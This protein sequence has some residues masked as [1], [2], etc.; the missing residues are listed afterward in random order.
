MDGYDN[1]IDLKWRIET[2]CE[3]LLI[4]FERRGFCSEPGVASSDSVQLPNRQYQSIFLLITRWPFLDRCVFKS[5]VGINQESD[6][7]KIWPGRVDFFRPG[8]PEKSDPWYQL[9]DYIEN[10]AYASNFIMTSQEQKVTNK[11]TGFST[12]EW[13]DWTISFLMTSW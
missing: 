3:N 5:N 2:D 8:D 12:I 9:F 1:G 13:F 11:I 4:T 6:F 10:S 7:F